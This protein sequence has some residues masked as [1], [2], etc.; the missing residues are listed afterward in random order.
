MHPRYILLT[1]TLA[2]LVGGLGRPGYTLDLD[3]TQDP[4]RAVGYK[5]TWIDQDV[6]PEVNYQG[7]RFTLSVMYSNTGEKPWDN[8]VC[9][10]IYKDAN[11]R[12][13]PNPSYDMEGQN[14]FGTS[15]W[16]TD[17]WV[18]NHRPVCAERTVQPGETYIFNIEFTIPQDTPYG[19]YFEDFSLAVDKDGQSGWISANAP[20]G[21]T[22]EHGKPGTGDPFGVAHIW[23][24]I[25]VFPPDE[26][27]SPY[28]LSDDFWQ[29]GEILREQEEIL[30]EEQDALDDQDNTWN[31]DPESIQPG[32]WYF[33]G[34]GRDRMQGHGLGLS[35]Y[36]AYG[37][38]DYGMSA[39]DIIRFYY[40]GVQLEPIGHGT[41]EVRGHGTMDIENYVAG[42]GEIP[43]RACGTEQQVLENPDKYALD[44]PKT[45]WDCWPEESIKAQV[46]AARAY[47]LTA[48]GALYTDARSQ[49]YKG[50][51]AK[52]WAVEET[53]HLVPTHNGNIIRAYYSSDNSQGHGTANHE[54]VWSNY[55]GDKTPL[56]Y[57]RSVDD[58]AFAKK[59]EWTEW[60]WTTG[61]FSYDQ[62]QKLLEYES[63]H[64][65][66]GQDFLKGV[67]DDIGQITGME[68]I[69]DPSYRVWKIKLI[70]TNGEREI[71]GWFFKAVWNEGVSDNLAPGFIYSLTFYLEQK[72]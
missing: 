43:D 13:A 64:F 48:G 71:A 57:L 56:P 18:N 50:G 17:S 58:S 35:Q 1:L 72:S 36:G 32:E 51:N 30:R 28:K 54:T 15:Y 60:K 26:K 55:A 66:S 45:I 37:A 70:G 7:D 53:A 21:E 68:F 33:R 12:T 22:D 44:S 2:L 29:S 34:Q 61:G 19:D 16:K 14:L 49:V 65:S 38:A 62:L 41:V 31:N 10:N 20:Y 27:S 69:R 63:E 42:L 59:T 6:A 47:A 40:V 39:E 67:L 11:R 23:F 46:I 9:L 24:P 4:V 25:N 8:D 3:H 52:R 5:A